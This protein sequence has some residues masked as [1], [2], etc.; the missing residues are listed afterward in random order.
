MAY[1]TSIA[2][3]DTAPKNAEDFI[4]NAIQ[5][6]LPAASLVLSS[7][8]GRV[9]ISKAQ[10]RF[11]VLDLLP[12]AYFVSGDTGLKQTTKADW[13]NKY[14]NVEELACIVPVPENVIDDDD[15]DLFASL[16]PQI[17][18]AMGAAIDAAV[19]FGVNKPT[20]W[21]L[22][23]GSDAN[24]IYQ[25]AVAK[26]NDVDATGDPWTDLIAL[27]KTT[28]ADGYPTTGIVGDSLV[29]YDLMGVLDGVGRP[30]FVNTD[31][32]GIGALAGRRFIYLDNGIWN[33]SDASLIAGKW[34]NLLVGM[35]KDLTFEVF[36]EGVI[37]DNTGAV[38]LN[39]MQQ[40]ARALRVTMRLAV[41]VG[42]P[43]NARN[44]GNADRYPFSVLHPAGS[45]TNTL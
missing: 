29:E 36:R 12:V 5:E 42:T 18:Q 37:T 34:S 23:S 17:V 2:R 31:T 8:P 15:F 26:G 39:L 16:R 45:P 1:N 10:A 38:V 30:L 20:S 43:I 32:Q 35:R 19:L 4:A 24:G 9:P 40:D 11:P 13:V 27:M 41:T 25:V 28:A 14:L 44:A 22:G 6:E 21:D 33:E 3:A 7:L